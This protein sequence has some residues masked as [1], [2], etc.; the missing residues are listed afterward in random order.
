MRHAWKVWS[1][2]GGLS[3]ENTEISL[4]PDHTEYM[5]LALQLDVVYQES[6]LGTDNQKAF[7]GNRIALVA[8]TLVST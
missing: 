3:I 6:I 8:P 4:F 2:P 5:V 7:A 1:E